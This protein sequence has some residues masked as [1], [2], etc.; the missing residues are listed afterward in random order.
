VSARP[1]GDAPHGWPIGL[2]IAGI[3][4]RHGLIRERL[5]CWRRA[6]IG[7]WFNLPSPAWVRDHGGDDHSSGLVIGETAMVEDDASIPV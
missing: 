6:S 5:K 3:A 4:L 7:P 2:S 1:G